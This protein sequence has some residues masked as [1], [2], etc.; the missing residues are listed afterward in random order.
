MAKNCKICKLEDN[1]FCDVYEF[2]DYVVNNITGACI[3]HSDAVPL[4]TWKDIFRLKMNSV[5]EIN[6]KKIEGPSLHLK[7]TTHSKINSGHAFLIYLIF[8]LKQPLRNLENL[9]DTISIRTICEVLN[10]VEENEN[11][12]NSVEYECIGD[13]NGT[14]LTNYK[15]NDID[16]PDG[17]SNLKKLISSKDLSQIDNKYIV[18]FIMNTTE[19]NQ[20]SDDYNFDF[21]FNGK[22]DTNL[23]ETKINENLKM[24]EINESSNCTFIIEKDRKANLNCALNIEKYKSKKYLTFNKTK[25]SYDD[26]NSIY[27]DGLDEVYLI[28]SDPIFNTLYSK[29]NKNNNKTGVIVGTIVSVLVVVILA[30]ITT[31]ICYK[32]KNKL[33]ASSNDQSIPSSVEN[34]YNKTSDNL[35]SN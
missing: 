33:K 6:G 35:N 22:I 34:N 14:D 28:N 8:K 5:K 23:S 30:A 25:I 17:N 20:T 29:N 12:A 27:L 13:S 31:Y 3:K 21:K 9:N 1:Y 26:E 16:V 24:N 18:L 19:N 4:I 32:R 11:E 7:G 15:L 2:E 10:E